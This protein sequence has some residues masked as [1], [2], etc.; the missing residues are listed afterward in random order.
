M[1]QQ[2]LP[3]F[4]VCV[5]YFGG[6]DWEH[7]RCM[8][9]VEQLGVPIFMTIGHPYIDMA[10]AKLVYDFMNWKGR[11]APLDCMLFIDHDIMFNAHDCVRIVEA[12]LE[13][14]AV[15]GGAYPKKGPGADLIGTFHKSVTEATFFQGGQLY[16][17]DDNGL[18]M[19]FTAIP[20][21]VIEK[22]DETLPL[23]ISGDFHVRP[24]FQ[25]LVEDGHYFGED[26]SFC[27]R[28]KKAGFEVL[29]DSRI[30]LAHKGSYKYTIEDCGIVVPQSLDT[31]TVRLKGTSPD[32]QHSTRPPLRPWGGLTEDQAMREI[33]ENPDAIPAVAPGGE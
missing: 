24:Y 28:V 22:L 2:T 12:A 7:E 21:A 11:M 31:L 26:F 29:L 23:C 30:R 19:G 17:T 13:R 27:R 4:C 16:P 25:H 5:P 1:T 3:K 33:Q 32:P 9:S 14:Q 18:G 10:R 8:R 15:V 6:K 20:R